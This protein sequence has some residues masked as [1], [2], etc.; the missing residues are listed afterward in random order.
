VKEKKEKM[1]SSILMC[2]LPSNYIEQLKYQISRF[3]MF[4]QDNV[5]GVL[6]SHPGTQL[7]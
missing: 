4:D 5:D 7:L 6:P 1:K 2:L 3:T